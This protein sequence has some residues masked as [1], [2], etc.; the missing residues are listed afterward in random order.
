LRDAIKEAVPA[1][2]MVLVASADEG[3]VDVDRLDIR[4]LPLLEDDGGAVEA[5]GAAAFEELERLRGEG[6]DYL[7]VP[8]DRLRSLE[9]RF[10]ELQER[11][12]GRYRAFLRDGGTCAIYALD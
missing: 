5:G 8:K 10:P 6:A 4:A 3:L 7:V 12:E 1:G 11:L 2:S 9:Y